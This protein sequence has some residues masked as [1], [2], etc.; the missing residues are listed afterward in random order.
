[1]KAYLSEVRS[2]LRFLSQERELGDLHQLRREDLE[3][4]QVSLEHR[5]KSNGKPLERS[6]RSRKVSTVKSFV[7]FLYRT[8]VL[9]RD[10]GTNIV[11]P[12]P[13]DKLLAQLPSQEEILALFEAPDVSTPLGLRDRAILE[14]L[15]SSALRNS[16]LRNLEVND[17]DLGR[18]QVRVRHGKG[19]RQRLVPLGEPAGV[20]IERYLKQARSFFLRSKEHGFLF[21]TIRGSQLKVP[22]LIDLVRKH[23]KAAGLG[24]GLT[25][26]SLRHCCATHMLANHVKFRHLQELLGHKNPSSTQIYTRVELSD[27]K[28]AHRIYHPARA[29]LRVGGDES[30]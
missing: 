6:G 30:Y 16:E 1:M 3:A 11:A 13:P 14:L 28:E 22:T 5:L 21:G 25:P 23:G 8:Q 17:V 15:Y 24:E 4:Y 7:R 27:L 20:W 10:L 26:H 19:S 12:R 2:F 9:L 18:L 29:L